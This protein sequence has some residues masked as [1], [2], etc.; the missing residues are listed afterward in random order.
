MPRYILFVICF[1]V[2]QILKAQE[3]ASFINIE[4]QPK[5]TFYSTARDFNVD[6]KLIKK[7]NEQYAPDYLAQNWRCC[8]S[9]QY[10]KQN[11]VQLSGNKKHLYQHKIKPIKS[12]KGE[13]AY[14]L[15]K[16]YSISPFKT[17]KQWNNMSS[18]LG[19]KLGQTLIVGKTKIEKSI[20]TLQL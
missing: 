20:P 15:C 13:T 4:I 14:G 8:S 9:T 5:Q 10:L 11:Q 2:L 1:F 17:S 3:P 6:I 7:Y 19:L 12:S 16:K 18:D